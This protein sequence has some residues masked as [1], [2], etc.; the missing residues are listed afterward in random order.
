M[1]HTEIM[2]LLSSETLSKGL[3]LEM[4]EC[5]S[6]KLH[7]IFLQACLVLSEAGGLGL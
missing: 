7:S 5:N 3:L 4:K 6:E 2:S 1:Y